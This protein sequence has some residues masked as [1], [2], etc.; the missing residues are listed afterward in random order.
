MIMMTSAEMNV[1]VMMQGSRQRKLQALPQAPKG[2]PD[3]CHFLALLSLAII[4]LAMRGDRIITW[5][6]VAGMSTM[7]LN[8]RSK[9]SLD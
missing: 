1:L 4:V 7:V 5:Y 9:A 8:V 3:L 2:G 6:P